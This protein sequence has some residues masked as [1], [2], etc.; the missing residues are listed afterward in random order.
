M[1]RPNTGRKTTV[2]SRIPKK[3]YK[4]VE[5]RHQIAGTQK[6]MAFDLNM[7]EWSIRRIESGQGDPSFMVAF[8]IAEYLGSSVYELFPDVV[9]EA[10]NYLNNCLAPLHVR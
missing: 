7:T 6:R 9:E 5:L 10:K 3:R 2:S 8:V 1:T 4:V